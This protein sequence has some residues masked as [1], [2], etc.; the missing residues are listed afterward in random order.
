MIKPI[1]FNIVV[2]VLLT[3]V[4]TY[5]IKKQAKQINALTQSHLSLGDYVNNRIAHLDSESRFFFSVIVKKHPEI[6]PK[7][8][9]KQED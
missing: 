9:C 7:Q 1:V 2:L 8:E 5:K 6:W 3:G 4:L